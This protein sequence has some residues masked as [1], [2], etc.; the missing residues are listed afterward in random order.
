MIKSSDVIICWW[1]V[2]KKHNKH[3]LQKKQVWNSNVEINRI[4]QQT[5]NN[6]KQILIILNK[7]DKKSK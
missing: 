5:S 7:Q 3:E 4:V 1:S 6:E 2:K